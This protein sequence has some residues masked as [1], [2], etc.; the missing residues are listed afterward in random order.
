MNESAKILVLGGVISLLYGTITGW[1]LFWNMKKNKGKGDRYIWA[2]HKASLWLGFM[3]FG[4][5]FVINHLQFSETVLI[6]L[7][8]G[9][10]VGCLLVLIGQTI[11]GIK[12]NPNLFTNP[13]PLAATLTGIGDII[14]MAVIILILYGV[15]VYL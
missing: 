11:L 3:I 13:S 10:N 9:L 7:S 12:R 4:I 8:W 15:I 1:W 6:A 14:I 5:A 2:T